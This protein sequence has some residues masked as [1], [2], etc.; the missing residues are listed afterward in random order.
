MKPKKIDRRGFMIKG[1]TSA[2][3]LGVLAG[4]DKRSVV[5]LDIRAPSAPLNLAGKIAKLPDDSIKVD[6]SWQKHDQ[7]D[8]TGAKTETAITYELYRDDIETPLVAGTSATSFTDTTDLQE[9][10]TYVYKLKAVD[11]DGNRSQFS[12]PLTVLIQP[13]VNIYVAT[14]PAAVPGTNL[15]RPNIQPDLV[16]SMVHACVM[17]LTNQSTVA[18]AWESLF[19]ALT[20]SSLIGIKINTLGMGNVSTK[21][22]VVDAI[23]DGL[24]R[25]LGGTFPAHN[26]VVFD[27]RGKDSHLKP[28]GYTLRNDPSTYRITSIWYNTTLDPAAPITVQQPDADLWGASVPVAGVTQRVSKLVEA[29]DY[30]INVPILKDHIQAGITFSMKNL[31]G[32]VDYPNLLHDNMC[33]PFIPAIYNMAAGGVPLRDKIRLIVGDALV[34]CS[35]GG[36]AGTPNIKPGVIVAGTDP[37]AMDKW[38]LDKIN[39]YRNARSQIPLTQVAGANQDARHI[40]SASQP[41]YS[42]GSTNYAVREVAL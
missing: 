24:T 1:L 29:L 27:D 30:M 22:P 4:C 34:G 35:F 15:L 23:V 28:A 2:V 41:P 32:L 39:S 17:Q 21:P 12:A 8:V 38:A 37:V 19:P 7:T 36:P 3:G 6:L 42:L 20:A 26:I 13:F 25:M 31:Y 14:N 40:F 18:G 16:K 11:Q 10:A 33:S 5:G 9:N